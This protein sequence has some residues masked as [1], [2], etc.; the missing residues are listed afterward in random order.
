M[1]WE[2][3]AL[4]HLLWLL[5]PVGWLLIRAGGKRR[6]DAEDFADAVMAPRLFP[7]PIR[8]RRWLRAALFLGGL[9]LLVAAAARPRFG[10]YYEE[11]SARGV[12][13]FVCV[14]VSRSM[15]ARDVAPN[16]LDRAKSDVLDLLQRLEGDRVGL[17]A[18][19]GRPV[20]L[21]PLTHDQGFFK[22]ILD[23]LSPRSAPRGGTQIGDA[24]REALRAMPTG[25]S[26]DQAIVLITDGEDQDSL[27]LDAADRAAA[28]KVKIFTV[29]LGDSEQGN[30]IPIEDRYGRDAFLE[31]E[32]EIVMSKLDEELLGE[33]ALRTGGAYIPAGTRA[34]DLGEIYATHLSELTAGEYEADKRKRYRE[35]FQL[36]VLLGLTL[37]ALD[38]LFGDYRSR[39]R[40]GLA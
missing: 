24:V 36:F 39:P 25:E 38:L 37:L 30:P 34:Y 23:E 4:L 40:E 27:P 9:A 22:T 18:F 3:P 2:N 17:I 16:R 19:A 31:H 32:G 20:V 33:L 5:L 28:R 12:D 6:A 21:C 26:R 13:L 10:V 11:V 35:R 14:D 29:G 7:R 1:I 8:G 15:L